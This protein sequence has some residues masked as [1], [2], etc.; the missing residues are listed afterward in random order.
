MSLK[1]CRKFVSQSGNGDRTGFGRGL[2]DCVVVEGCCCCILKPP[3]DTNEDPLI[4]CTRW[5]STEED[6]EAVDGDAPRQD[7]K[8]LE[9][10]IHDHAGIGEV[11]RRTARRRREV[12]GGWQSA[13]DILRTIRRLGR[14]NT[15]HQGEFRGLGAALSKVY[16]DR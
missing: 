1:V 16:A 4:P 14:G 7:R 12:R 15:A 6:E 13:P 9:G 2:S 5:L 8:E 3:T 11:R 10:W